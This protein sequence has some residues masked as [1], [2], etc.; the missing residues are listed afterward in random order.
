MK[1]NGKMSVFTSNFNNRSAEDAKKN[2][3]FQI[4]EGFKQT[5]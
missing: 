4:R 3:I 5:P 2:K 1:R